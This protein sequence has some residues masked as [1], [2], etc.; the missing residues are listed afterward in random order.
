MIVFDTETTGLPKAEGSSLDQQPKIIEF[1]AVKLDEDLKEIE[2]LE[3]FCHPG[4]DLPPI[5]T[6]ITGIT[7]DKLKDEKPFVAYYQQV[8]EFFLGEKTLVAHNL[9]FDRKLLKFE[10]ERIDKLTKFPWPYEHICTVEV[11]ESVWGKKRKLGDIYEE[12]TGANMK[13][14]HRATADVEA[15]IEVVKWYKK[16][17]HLA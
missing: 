13:G 2:R 3:F 15:L 16:E 7:D 9:P 17:G 1:G 5:I 14:A 11:G 4:Y 6:K 12:L 10:L 8:C